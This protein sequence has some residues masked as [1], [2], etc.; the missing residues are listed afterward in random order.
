MLIIQLERGKIVALILECLRD[1]PGAASIP[2]GDL[3][4]GL[5]LLGQGSVLD[6]IGLVTLI[7]DVEQRLAVEH[8]VSITLASESAM[9]RRQSPFRTVGAFADY[10]CELAKDAG[11]NV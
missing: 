6:S 1:L 4:E 9:S 5:P 10:I 8:D 7:V 11:A 3:N 2:K